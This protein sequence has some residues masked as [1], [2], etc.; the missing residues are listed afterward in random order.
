MTQGEEPRVEAVARP[1]E[2]SPADMVPS[3][4]MVLRG[5]N[6]LVGS[7]LLNGAA[8][9]LA[10]QVLTRQGVGT[11]R[12]LA[13]TAVFPVLGLIVQGVR[14]RRAD[15]IAVLSLVIIAIGVAGSLISNDP[16]FFLVRVSFG[17][18]AFGVACL[19]SLAFGR[20]L[21]FY[22]G[23][24]VVAAG[25]PARAAYFDSRW[26]FPQFRHVQRV[27]T[28]TWG[29]GYLAEAA[30]RVVLA[31]SLPTSTVL[32]LE[33]LLGVAVFAGLLTWTMRYARARARAAR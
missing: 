27:M 21:L 15:G 33:P 11:V 8:P 9:L 26:A 13:L 32:L 24:Q 1:G 10:Y 20:P 4:G 6:G 5:P 23:R 29:V 12:A 17:T 3:L 16:R 31:W 2:L 28:V 25:D 7:L 18:A 14:T 22:L 30:A 19:A